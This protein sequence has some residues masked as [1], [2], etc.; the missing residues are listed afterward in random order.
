M[1]RRH[2]DDNGF[3]KLKQIIGEICQY[4]EGLTVEY[5]DY[6]ISGNI[7]DPRNTVFGNRIISVNVDFIQGI[8]NTP[9]KVNGI[10]IVGGQ[11][12]YL[13]NSYNT[14]EHDL[15]LVVKTNANRVTFSSE[16]E[17]LILYN[18][19]N[20]LENGKGCYID[21][22][23]KEFALDLFFVHKEN[24]LEPPYLQIYPILKRV[25]S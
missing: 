14:G 10:Y 9:F 1:A 24:P 16:V 22:I 15:D 5:I 12:A 21:R 6:P 19:A 25:D 4:V 20:V 3:P 17:D 2:F 11:V 7:I 23:K 13:P 8:P 18:L